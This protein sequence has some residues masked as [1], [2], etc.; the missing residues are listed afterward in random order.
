[1]KIN[2]VCIGK[3]KEKY[4]N[5][6]IDEFLKRL[7]PYAKINIIEKSESKINDNPSTAQIQQVID[8]EGQSILKE[9]KNDDFVILLDLHGKMIDN[10]EYVNL[11][12]KAMV[13]GFS[14]FTFVIGG[15]YGVSPE[16]RNR[17]NFKWA[18][19]KLTFTHQMIRLLLLEQI[20][21]GFRIKNNEPYHK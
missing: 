17:A 2:I 10:Y 7:K 15:S 18:F 9:I 6:G 8:I 3:I 12:E 14:T 13:Q 19:S 11:I 21:R 4:L 20:Y 5:L 16:L 1:M